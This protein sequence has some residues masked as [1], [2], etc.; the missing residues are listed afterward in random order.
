MVQA[1]ALPHAAAPGAPD[2]VV[3][4]AAPGAL[5]TPGFGS[6]FRIRHVLC[7]DRA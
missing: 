4:A 7:R 1:I 6:W 2:S 5:H 3:L